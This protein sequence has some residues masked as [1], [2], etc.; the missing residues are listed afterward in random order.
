MGAHRLDGLRVR[1]TL[2]GVSVA[3]LA[4]RAIVSCALIDD[5][6]SGGSCQPEASDRILNALAP[7]VALATNT[8]A[9]P[10]VFT[11]TAGHS[12]QTGDTV[13]IA[14]N[15]TSN[16]DP[17]GVRVVTRVSATQFS[18]PIDC[19]VAGGTAGTATATPATLGLARL[20]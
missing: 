16:A 12:F 5:L 2:A 9:N 13:T 11:V 17:N 15:L 3:E 6:E 8:Q 10:T 19:L 1:R 20:T 14:G 7:A 18:V 4:A